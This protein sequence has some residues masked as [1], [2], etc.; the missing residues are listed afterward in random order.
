MFV[1]LD[2]ETSSIRR[3]LIL[4]ISC[5]STE[6]DTFNIFINPFQNL[7][8]DCTNLTGF[9]YKNG[10]LFKDG[11]FIHSCH[12]KHALV[13]LNRFI[14]MLKIK[15]DSLHI[16]AHNGLAFDLPVLVRAYH[17][18]KMDLPLIDFV[19]DTVPI[20]RKSTF[21]IPS[22]KLKNLAEHF[23]LNTENIEFHNSL[24]DCRILLNICQKASVMSNL[25]LEQFFKNQSKPFKYFVDKY[26][27]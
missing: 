22:L 16:I 5:L 14:N 10:S 13:S 19:R 27:K 8:P 7:P 4:Q 18:I 1:I 17:R 26:Y 24:H 6:N 25:T 3:P 2:I 15:H 23:K 11:V 20:F 9:S 21:K 12:L